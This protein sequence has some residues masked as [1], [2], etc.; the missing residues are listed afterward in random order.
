M[1]DNGDGVNYALVVPLIYFCSMLGGYI[2]IPRGF[3]T[4]LASIPQAVQSIL[5]KLGKWNMAAVLHDLIYKFNGAVPLFTREGHAF[6]GSIDR[7]MADSIL[8]EAM[9]ATGVDPVHRT[10]IYENVSKFGTGAWNGHAGQSD[11][12]PLHLAMQ[13]FKECPRCD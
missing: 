3:V 13:D 5:P 7:A 11:A 8:R 1:R 4:D 12:Y 9:E 2:V 6:D 10:L